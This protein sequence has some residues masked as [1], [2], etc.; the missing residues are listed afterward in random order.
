MRDRIIGYLRIHPTTLNMLWKTARITLYVLGLFIPVKDKTL[1][2]AS[3]GGRK[4]DDSPRAIYE[5]IVKRTEFKDWDLVWAFT[6]PEKH[7]IPRGRKIKIDTREFFIMLLKSRVWVSNSGMDRNI[8]LDRKKTIKIETWHG[9]PMKRIGPDQ[10]TGALGEQTVPQKEDHRTIRCAQSEYDR[11]IFMRVFNASKDSFLMCD[12]PRNDKLL[13]Y[14]DEEV[15]K[16]KDVLH[17]PEGKRVFLYMPTYREYQID[18]EGNYTFNIPLN[19]KKWEKEL[20]DGFVLLVR[21]HY[22]ISFESDVWGGDRVIDVSEYPILSDLYAVSDILISDYSSAYFDY[23]ILC[24]PMFCYAFDYE[25]Y[26]EKRGV[27]FDLNEELPCRIDH[28]EEALL[29][30][31]KCMDYEKMSQRTRLF[32]EK[33][34]PH[35]GDASGAVVKELLKRLNT[36]TE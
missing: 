10:N 1:L 2:F 32:H 13:R 17:I 5:E 18:A 21:K 24:R 6:E 7:N 33:Y 34:T 8:G 14:T 27:Y 9:T 11:N 20:G 36:E 23:S 29:N 22:A 31:I 12:L 19:I 28:D 4:F 3:F 30:S 35:A 16:I 25:E 26:I 15:H